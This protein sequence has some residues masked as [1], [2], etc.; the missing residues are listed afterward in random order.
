ME[1]NNT[2]KKIFIKFFLLFLIISVIIII[3]LDEVEHKKEVNSLKDLK[4][5]FSQSICKFFYFTIN[6]NCLSKFYNNDFYKDALEINNNIDLL[7]NIKITKLEN[8]V[9]L[10]GIIP[11]LKKNSTLFYK[12]NNK[13][14][15]NYIKKIIKNKKIKHKIIKLDYN[16]FYTFNEKMDE[17]LS[18]KWELIPE[19]VMLDNLRYIINNYYNES[20]FDIFQKSLYMNYDFYIQRK[21]KEIIYSDLVNLLSKCNYYIIYSQNRK[22]WCI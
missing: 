20:N 5:Y 13:E 19:K 12:I 18:Y 2:M 8:I 3:I 7:M 16:D 21:R 6:Y 17:L 14:I 15:Y 1:Y 4:D 22:H 10:L 11:F 9:L